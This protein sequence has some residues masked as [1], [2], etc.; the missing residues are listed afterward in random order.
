Q[1]GLLH[2]YT[3]RMST[4]VRDSGTH[5]SDRP[6]NTA[7]EVE[8][9]LTELNNRHILLS[10]TKKEMRGPRN[11]LMDIQYSLLPTMEFINEAKKAN[12]RVTRLTPQLHALDE[13]PLQD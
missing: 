10:I 12:L 2:P 8:K 11:K 3:I 9:A 7:R 1:A 13:K 6:Y 5:E 4:I